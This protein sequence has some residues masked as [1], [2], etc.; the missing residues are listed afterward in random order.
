MDRLNESIERFD[1]IITFSNTFIMLIIIWC[2]W[3]F[4]S[5]VPGFMK[6]KSKT[7]AAACWSYHI[8]R[9]KLMHKAQI[10]WAL[11]VRRWIW[12]EWGPNWFGWAVIGEIISSCL[13][14]CRADFFRIIY[15][16]LLQSVGAFVVFRENNVWQERKEVV[17]HAFLTGSFMKNFA[18][19]LRDVIWCVIKCP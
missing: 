7:T 1:S 19:W 5:D 2:G 18:F 16:Q 14:Y 9:F 4:F 11:S 13:L 3:M 15:S 8:F 6:K 12:V 10:W 17:R